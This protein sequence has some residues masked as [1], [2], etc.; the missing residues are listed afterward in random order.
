MHIHFNTAFDTMAHNIT[1]SLLGLPIEVLY[2]I[3]DQLDPK[4][5]LLSVRNV[6]QRLDTITD[7]YHPYQVNLTIDFSSDFHRFRSITRH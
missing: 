4:H 3:L 1:I 5:I 7:T 2:R 6:C